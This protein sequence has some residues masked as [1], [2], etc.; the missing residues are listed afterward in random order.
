MKKKRS[1]GPYFLK[2]LVL[3][4][5]VLLISQIIPALIAYS[6]SDGKYGYDAIA[7]IFM[8]LIVLIVVLRYGNSYIFTEKRDKLRNTLF[9]GGPMLIVAIISF[10]GSLGELGNAPITNI[11]N[12]VIL[13]FAIG[14]AEEF[15]CRGWIQNEFIE[16]YGETRK[17]V[18]LSILCASVIFGLM[19]YANLIAGQ[20]LFETTLQVLQAISSGFLFGAI[21]FRTKNIWNTV[22]LHGFYDLSLFLSEVALYKDCTTVTSPDMAVRIYGYFSSLL[23]VAVYVLTAI[24]VLRKEKTDHLIEKE[25]KEIPYEEKR[26]YK[27]L[28][29]VIAVLFIII[30]IPL[31][32]GEG[33]NYRICYS[34]GEMSTKGLKYEIHYPYYESYSIEN[35]YNGEIFNLV[36]NTDKEDN[37]YITNNVLNKK[38]KIAETVKSFK[39]IENNDH[40]ILIIS[41]DDK[42]LY[43]KENYTDL[44]N[45]E[46][47][48]DKIKDKLKTVDVPTVKELGYMTTENEE[49][50]L[51][52]FRTDLDDIFVIKNEKKVDVLK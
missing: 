39:V 27:I 52:I 24:Y 42:I 44:E 41:A 2:M 36:F 25:Y 10:I 14:V 45:T 49:D 3:G 16:R 32:L 18:I 13:C 48:M 12:V 1:L 7:E 21:Y 6:L 33:K 23:I 30:F 4:I 47:Y 46:E 28:K 22:L 19:H 34:Y 15:L 20:G 29:W 51:P 5:F 38:V 11:V 17:G 35:T 50:K 9:I 31:D 37:L 26:K 8:A 40:L 43:L